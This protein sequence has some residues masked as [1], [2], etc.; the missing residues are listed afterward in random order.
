MTITANTD[1]TLATFFA[2]RI[3]TCR[4]GIESASRRLDD[5]AEMGP[6]E[7]GYFE[8]CRAVDEL[9]NCINGGKEELRYWEARKAATA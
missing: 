4:R 1:P 6:G 5:L 9:S 3:A 7:C 2:N 8:H